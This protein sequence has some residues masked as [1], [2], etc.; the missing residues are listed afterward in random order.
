MFTYNI[1]IY[2]FEPEPLILRGFPAL[3]I[4]LSVE[5]GIVF[6]IFKQRAVVKREIVK[7][8]DPLVIKVSVDSRCFRKDSGCFRRVFDS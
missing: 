4:H 6:I 3:L 7:T 5:N 8:Y 1:L 2:Q